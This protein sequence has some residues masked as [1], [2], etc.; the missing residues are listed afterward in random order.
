[1]NEHRPPHNTLLWW[2]EAIDGY[3]GHSFVIGMLSK[4]TDK[5]CYIIRTP[6]TTSLNR[7]T[8]ILR[9]LFLDY[10]LGN[11]LASVEE[12]AFLLLLFGDKPFEQPQDAI[13]SAPF[14]DLM[15]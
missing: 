9:T 2:F 3:S 4:P 13:F 1:M 15:Q 6:A 8:R 7:K 5:H 11:E 10:W 14:V 12:C